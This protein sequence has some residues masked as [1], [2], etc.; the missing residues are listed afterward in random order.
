MSQLRFS[1]QRE[2]ILQTLSNKGF[3]PIASEIFH[4]VKKTLPRISRATVYRNLECL[5][6][7]GI[8]E[9]IPGNPL[10]YENIRHNGKHA[11][12]ICN[13]CGKIEDIK[14]SE[15]KFLEKINGENLMIN[16]TGTCK[17]CSGRLKNGRNNNKSRTRSTS[18]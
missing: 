12:F 13:N 14:L 11:H 18:I 16:I 2:I 8:I 3:H 10:R 15:E 9:I 4:E 6:K 5:E 17:Q 1:S 7:E